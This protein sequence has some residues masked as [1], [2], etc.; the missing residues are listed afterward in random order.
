LANRAHRVQEAFARLNE[1]AG[2]AVLAWANCR[3]SRAVIVVDTIQDP[4]TLGTDN[5][6]A[7]GIDQVG[8]FTLF[9]TQV[10]ARRETLAPVGEIRGS[11]AA[12]T[13]HASSTRTDRRAIEVFETGDS[14]ITVADS[15]RTAVRSEWCIAG[16][17]KR[18]F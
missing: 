15:A 10:G 17:D 13:V 3:K 12:R 14:R 9:V 7:I 6:V 8:A 11:E 18:Q 16:V 2:P 5:A 1:H 4:L